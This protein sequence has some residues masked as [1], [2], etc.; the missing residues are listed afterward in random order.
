MR[1]LFTLLT[2]A[3]IT[4]SLYAQPYPVV[5]I[6]D[7]NTPVDLANCNDTSIYY[8][9]TVTFVGYVVTDGGLCENASG[10]ISGANGIR[11]FIWMNDSANGGAVGPRTGLEVMGVNWGTSQATDDFTTYIE[12]DLLEVTGVVGM[13]RGATQFQPL[14]NNSITVLSATT[15]PTFTPA[16][17]PVGD[18]NDANQVN[19][20][21]TGQPWEGGFIEIKNVT[22]SNLIPQG[23]GTTARINFVVTDSAGNAILIDDFFLAMKL[24]T[25]Q[26]LNPNSPSSTGSFVAPAVGTFYSSIIGVVEHL[27][28]GCAGGTGNGYAIHPFKPS[29]FTVASLPPSITNVANSPVVPTSGD[30]IQITADISDPD[31]TVNSVSIYWSANPTAP[32]SAFTQATMTNTSG[33]IY[34]YTIPAQADSSL[35]RYYIEAEDDA[36]NVSTYPTTPTGQTQNTAI[37][38]VRDGIL[39]IS[40]IQTPF[41]ATGSSPLD[42]QTVT[43]RGFVTAANRDCDLGYVY[44]QDTSAT[45]YAGLALRSSLD[46][47]SVY[48]NEGIEVTGAIS[49]SF[50]FTVMTVQSVTSLGV[51]AEVDPIIL[52]PS[53]M[54]EINEYEKYESML[55]TYENPNGQ[56]VVSDEDA[57]FAEYRVANAPGLTGEGDSRRILAGRQDGNSAQ[58]SLYVQ[59]VTDPSWATD[60]GIMAFPPVI[61][62]TSITMDGITGLLYYSFGNFKLTPRNNF[63]FDNISG[64]TLDN[65]TCM[66]PFFSISEV[67]SFGSVNIYPNPASTNITI[68]ASAENISAKLHG[69][70]GKILLSKSSQNR[71]GRIEM[72]VSQLVPGV[73]ILKVSDDRNSVLS[74]HKVIIT[75]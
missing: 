21:S 24:T 23:S 6:M 71:E 28:N 36:Q 42:G 8:L 64:V 3:F 48:R 25:W 27:S 63:D 70:D 58:S 49:E 43:V 5:S 47:N 60:D 34:E 74:T 38:L 52:D 13:F 18:L 14:D 44:I 2:A 20:I 26:T 73:Y 11:P 75:K 41:D 45:E 67:E 72:N 55:V 39:T 37:V 9:D 4:A 61:T 66:T 35:V 50:G 46:L 53:D 59:L 30:P 68:E 56:I 62:N 65:S 54:T 1:N 51:G 31:G 15:F 16:V 29:H 69:I 22:V 40:D 19:Q 10:S 32:V 57:G 7:I 17:V 12:G 33:N